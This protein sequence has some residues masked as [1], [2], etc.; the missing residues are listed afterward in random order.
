MNNNF[1]NKLIDKGY[2]SCETCFTVKLKRKGIMKWLEN[3]NIIKQKTEGFALI[4]RDFDDIMVLSSVESHNGI[5]EIIN[6]KV[7]GVR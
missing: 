5:V 3:V 4:I 1:V 6:K 2:T 7:N